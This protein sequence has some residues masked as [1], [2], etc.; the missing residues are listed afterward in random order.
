MEW[1]ICSREILQ[2][3]SINP[4]FYADAVRDLLI[5]GRGKFRNVTITGPANCGKTFMLKPLEIVCHA[6]SN[7]ANDK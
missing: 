4:Y 1:Y 2:K 5:H 6:F 7:Q 3:N